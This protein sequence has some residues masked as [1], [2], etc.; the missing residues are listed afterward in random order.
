MER[1][2]SLESRAG[3]HA[4]EERGLHEVLDVVPEAIAKE[5]Q[6]L[7]EIAVEQPLPRA[8]ILLI[9]PGCEERLIA[10]RFVI[11]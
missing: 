1:R 7:G 6:Y 11:C 5:L 3:L 2:A 10:P 9:R 4:G 8:A